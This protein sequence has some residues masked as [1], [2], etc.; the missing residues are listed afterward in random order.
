[1]QESIKVWKNILKALDDGLVDN[2]RKLKYTEAVDF[3]ET[4][5]QHYHEV[6]DGHDELQFEV[7]PEAFTL[8][9]AKY[10]GTV[11]LPG[12]IGDTEVIHF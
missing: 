11:E 4:W 2:L 12:D 9:L 3:W 6:W 7:K 8:P 1:M 10:K 5:L